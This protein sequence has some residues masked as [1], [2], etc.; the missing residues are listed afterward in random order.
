MN[1]EQFF[2]FISSSLGKDASKCS[3]CKNQNSS[4]LCGGCMQVAFC[5]EACH[6]KAWNTEHNLEC[7]FIQ[8][9]VEDTNLKNDKEYIDLADP[10]FKNIL[11]VLQTFLSASGVKNLSSTSKYF[12]KVMRKAM[13]QSQTYKISKDVLNDRHFASIAPHIQNV[14]IDDRLSSEYLIMLKELAPNIYKM[15]FGYTFN[16]DVRG[17]LPQ[18][19]T[20]LTFGHYF[21]QDVRGA[22]PQSLTHLTFGY[23]FNQDVRGALPQSLTHLAFGPRFNRDVGRGALPEN[24]TH[25]TFGYRFNQDVS[26]GALPQSLTHLTFGFEFDQDVRGALPRSLTHLTFGAHFNQDLH[27]ALSQNLT[28]LTFGYRF[29][30]DV[31]RGALPQSLTRLTFGE[32]FNQDVH[33]ALP[34]SLTHL[35]FGT[36]FNQDVSHGALPQSLTHLTFGTYFNQDVSHGALPQSLTHLTFGDRFNQDVSHGALPQ[37]LTHLTFGN[38]FNRELVGNLPKGLEYFKMIGFD[39]NKIILNLL[40]TSVTTI[41]IS[42]HDSRISTWKQEADR[43]GATLETY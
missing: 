11:Q 35:T 25:L 33:G 12:N 36:S 34:Q 3:H 10:R 32:H 21:N 41:I 18:S 9:D 13:F 27:G 4:Y 5:G 17:A 16:Q 30:R 31:G 42:R 38:R 14:F 22:L 19:L 24:L 28:H 8:G 40:P 1:T 23:T 37:R 7:V 15:T 26:R 39:Y 43:I 29:N 6:K 20:H 2:N